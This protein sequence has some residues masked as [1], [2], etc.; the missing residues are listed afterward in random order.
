MLRERGY[1]TV[2]RLAV[3][4]SARLSVSNVQ[5]PWSRKLEYFENSFLA[6]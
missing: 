5:V 3:S 6:D 1:A 4:L 2:S